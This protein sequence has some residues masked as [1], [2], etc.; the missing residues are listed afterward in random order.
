EETVKSETSGDIQKG[1]LAI[2]RCVRSRP[3]FFAEQMRKSMKAR[4]I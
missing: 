3:H 1:I 4:E 2:I